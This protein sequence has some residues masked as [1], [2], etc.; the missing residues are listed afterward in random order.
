MT[1]S[2]LASLV[3][4]LI[5]APAGAQ[6]VT[7][8]IHSL[9]QPWTAEFSI[10][11]SVS[12]Y[13]YTSKSSMPRVLRR[14]AVTL[15]T[16]T[17]LQPEFRAEFDGF[18]DAEMTVMQLIVKSTADAPTFHAAVETIAPK[19]PVS[20]KV[21]AGQKL[22]VVYRAPAGAQ[23]ELRFYVG[24]PPPT[25][26]TSMPGAN[27]AT[28][29]ALD[30]PKATDKPV[31]RESPNPDHSSAEPLPIAGDAATSAPARAL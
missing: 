25:K 6:V 27:D 8:P 17:L 10:T 11:S 24:T 5:A 26:V 22:W 3:T 15:G 29:A 21:P 18:R 12:L 13:G 23:G 7:V 28:L 9:W 30:D 2:R 31:P 20:V 1:L 4:L 14:Q 16:A 19:K